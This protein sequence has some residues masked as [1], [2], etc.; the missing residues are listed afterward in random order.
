MM[1]HYADLTA[2]KLLA[3]SKP[4]G[5]MLDEKFHEEC[6]Q[7]VAAVLKQSLSRAHEKQ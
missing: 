3:Q 6:V 1:L 5:M 2:E 4:G 7:R